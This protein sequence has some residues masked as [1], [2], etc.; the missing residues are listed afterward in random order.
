[1]QI[2][3]ID[4]TW[5]DLFQPIPGLRTYRHNQICIE[6]EVIP[7]IFIPGIMGSRLVRARDKIKLWDPDD[8]GF[9]FGNYGWLKDAARKRKALLVG[10][11]FSPYHAHVDNFDEKHN[12]KMSSTTDKNRVTRGWGGV[13]W[14]SYG[15]ILIAMQ[16]HRWP[17]PFCHCF[18]MPVHA[19]G[20]NWC[21]SNYL[22]GQALS[23]EIERVIDF[24]RRGPKGKVGGPYPRMCNRVI[25][26]THSMGGLVARSACMLHGAK[27][28]VLGVVHG[29]QPATGSPAAYWRMKAGFERPRCGPNRTIWDWLRNPIKM[30]KHKIVGSASAFIL[31]SD[32]EEVTS[33]L[34]NMPGG[35]EL[36]PTKD[37]IDNASNS[38]WLNYP[39]RN[40]DIKLPALDPYKEIY[41]LEDP[42]YRMVNPA[43]LDPPG[44]ER[45][46]TSLQD[47]ERQQVAGAW[48]RYKEYL[49]QAQTFHENLGTSFHP[50]TYQFYGTDLDSPDKIAFSR[51]PYAPHHPHVHYDSPFFNKG[52]YATYVDEKDRILADGEGAV[53]IVMMGMPD[54]KGDGTVPVSSGNAL[55]I[56]KGRTEMIGTDREAWFSIGHQDICSTPAAKQFIFG[57]ITQILQKHVE[58]ECGVSL[59]EVIL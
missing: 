10:K 15:D 41:L 14:G 49:L 39:G 29:V 26:V 53:D 30:A 43:W 4:I 37:Y 6:R 44:N 11:K 50:E 20:Y 48:D 2:N 23:Q 40:G 1:M 3:N 13:M 38:S 8:L 56:D 57:S 21:A 58:N 17:E 31:G 5:K 47:E 24:Y 42:V 36:L 25:L 27:E 19:F 51:K 54:G 12:R 33:L 22:S 55:R 45:N 35:L 52:T 9:M 28:K 32:G 18:E 59:G 46:A 16:E 7:I 34:S